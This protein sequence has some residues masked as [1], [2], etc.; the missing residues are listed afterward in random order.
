MLQ[1]VQSQLLCYVSDKIQVSD[2]MFKDNSVF[3]VGA[4]ASHEF[5]LPIGWDLTQ[6]IK[7]NCDIVLNQ[8]GEYQSGSRAVFNHYVRMFSTQSEDNVDKIKSRLRASWQIRDG[9]ESADSIDEYIFRY[10]S[11]PLIAEVGKLNIAHAISSAESKSLLKVKEGSVFDVRDATNTWIWGFA[12]A[13]MNGIRADDVSEVGN[14]ITIICF[15]YDRCIEHYLEHA[16]AQGFHGLTATEAK[17]IVE[18][19]NIIHPYGWLGDLQRFPYGDT[20][21]FPAMADNIITWSESVRDPEII[22]K[23]R[24]AIEGASQ[25][26]FMGFGFAAQN[27]DLLDCRRDYVPATPPAV[28]S[29]GYS[30]P[31][32]TQGVLTSKIVSLYSAADWYDPDTQKVHFQYGAT[33][34]EFFDIHRLNLVI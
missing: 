24:L 26:V 7:A 30:L 33:C 14:N 29:T 25:I 22:S 13:L 9:I 4:G 8:W 31:R 34:K 5:G 2:Q 15:N 16:L 23:M 19:I 10:T 12:K 32:E 1:V 3:V 18:S 20:R 27:M 21:Q 17:S 6:T 28:Y 11:D